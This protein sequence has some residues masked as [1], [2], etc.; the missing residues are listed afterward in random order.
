VLG[1]HNR[2]SA[3]AALRKRFDEPQLEHE[4]HVEG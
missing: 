4:P 1:V 2:V 3:A